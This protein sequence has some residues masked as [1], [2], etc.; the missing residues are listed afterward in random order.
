MQESNNFRDSIGTINEEGNRNVIFPKKPKGKF[1][2]Y[3]TYENR[4]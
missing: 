3:R 2:N 1:T 4:V